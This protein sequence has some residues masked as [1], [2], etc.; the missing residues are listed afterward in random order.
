LARNSVVVA[1]ADLSAGERR[2]IARIGAVLLLRPFSL[3]TLLSIVFDMVA[4]AHGP[5]GLVAKTRLN[6]GL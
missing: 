1:S 3:V 5:V 4:P 2:R 6:Y